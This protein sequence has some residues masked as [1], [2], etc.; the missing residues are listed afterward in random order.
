MCGCFV[1]LPD[2]G[3]SDEAVVDRVKVRPALVRGERRRAARDCQTRQ[4]GHDEY[5]IDLGSFGTLAA[6]CPLRLSDHHGRE[7]VQ[8]LADTL[9][10]D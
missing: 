10:H 6:K 9:E 3:E 4:K 2:G 8:L 7:F 1:K 5:E